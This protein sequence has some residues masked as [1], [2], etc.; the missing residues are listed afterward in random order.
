MSSQFH[1]PPNLYGASLDAYLVKGWFRSAQYIYTIS[2]IPLE[3]ALY[4]PIRIRLPLQNYKFRKSLRKIIKKNKQFRTISRKATIT[5]EKEALY[6]KFI[7]RFDTYISPTLIDALQEGGETTI[8]NTYEI[9]VYDGDKLIAVSFFDLGKSAIASI[10]G[11]FDPAYDKYS[12]GFYTML[13]EIQYGKTNGFEYYYPGYVIPDYP[14]F[15]YK[16]RIGEVE[17]Y[18][19]ESDFWSRNFGALYYDL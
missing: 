1:R 5:P 19:A 6:Q 12:L 17:F 14:K 11:V 4:F 15:D 13:A 8:Y 3:G 9:A 10:K 2:S 7:V 18:D 16:M